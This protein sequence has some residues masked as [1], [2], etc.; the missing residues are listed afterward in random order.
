MPSSF[1]QDALSF[2]KQLFPEVKQV[3]SSSI[4]QLSEN[5]FIH[6]ISLRD[7][8]LTTDTS[9]F[10]ELTNEYANSGKQ[11]IQLWEDHWINHREIIVSRL[12]SFAGITTKIHGRKTKVVRIQQDEFYAFLNQNHLQGAVHAKYKF[13]LF[14]KDKLVAV[15]GFSHPRKIPRN[16]VISRSSELIRFCNLTNHTVIGGMDKLLKHFIINFD[17]DDIMSY[18]D[19]DWSNGKSYE[20]LGFDFIEQTSPTSFWIDL[21]T[22]KRAFEHHLAEQIQLE[23]EA[24]NTHLLQNDYLRIS[25]SGNLKFIKL[26]QNK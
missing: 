10:E 23:G 13:G 20:R 4:F 12:T 14:E 25:N 9:Y 15:A 26:I 18:A 6:L 11:L 1:Q 16:G 22:N 19:R 17:I 5:L 7:T 8:K 3:G 2:I 21:K 24:L